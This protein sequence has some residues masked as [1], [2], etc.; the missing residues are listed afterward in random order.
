M[1]KSLWKTLSA[2]NRK[3]M[4]PTGYRPSI[5]DFIN[6]RATIIFI[7]T[8][9][10]H[11]CIG[12]WY[13]VFPSKPIDESTYEMLIPVSKWEKKPQTGNFDALKAILALVC[14]NEYSII[15]GWPW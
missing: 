12:V 11:P 2:E 1:I 4:S 9:G 6:E 7:G 15:P 3:Q 14:D 13:T 8:N 10:P 5:D